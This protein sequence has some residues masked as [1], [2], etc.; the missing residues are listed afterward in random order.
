MKKRGI[1]LGILILIIGL[2]VLFADSV[3]AQQIPREQIINLPGDQINPQVY[4]RYIVY[5][6]D[7]GNNNYDIHV[8]DSGNT[9]SLDDD[10][11]VIPLTTDGIQHRYSNP[12]IDNKDG[13]FIA[14]LDKN[15][16]PQKIYVFDNGQDK[17]INTNDDVGVK[18]IEIGKYTERYYVSLNNLGLSNGILVF[19]ALDDG[20]GDRDILGFNLEEN[21]LFVIS[22]KK[23]FE[24]NDDIYLVNEENPSITTYFY[25][26][27]PG[28]ENPFFVVYYTQEPT[29]GEEEPFREM[30]FSPSKSI[31]RFDSRSGGRLEYNV[32]GC[33][34]KTF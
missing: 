3:I 8:Y 30:I 12:T 28:N 6:Q 25:P 33:D 29:I 14:W 26:E 16:D 34:L 5:L 31:Y 10:I 13:R 24:F 4:G 17:I 15:S 23:N 20:A 27:G 18:E 9:L 11:G 21:S 19:D 22:G 32:V 2:V 1:S 7:L